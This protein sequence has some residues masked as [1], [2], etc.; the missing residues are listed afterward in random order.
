[1]IGLALAAMFAAAAGAEQVTAWDLESDDGGFVATPGLQWEW[2]AIASYGPASGFES[3]SAWGTGVDALYKNELPDRLTL[4]AVDLGGMTAPVIGWW[5]WVELAEGDFAWL[6]AW[7]PDSGAWVTIDPVYG[8][9]GNDAFDGGDPAWRQV[10]VDLTG[11]A[12]LSYLQLVFSPSEKI[13]AAGWYVDSFTLWEGDAVPPSLSELTILEDTQDVLGPYE[14]TVTAEDD[15]ALE[16]VELR[17]RVDGGAIEY[18]VAMSDQGDGS[19]AGWLPGQDP[20]TTLSYY[21]SATDGENQAVLPREE[22][23][24][25]RVYLPAPSGLTGPDTHLADRV[26]TLSWDPPDTDHPLDGYSV[27]RDGQLVTKVDSSPAEVPLAES[28]NRFSVSAVF[29]IGDENWDGD[30]SEEIEL[31]VAWPDLL[32]LSPDFAYQGDEVR[33]TLTGQNLLM[34][35]DDLALDLGG[36]VALTGLEVRDVDVAVAT[37]TIDADAE[38]GLRDLELTSGALALS[39]SDVFEVVDGAERPQLLSVEPA[40]LDQG[41]EAEL[42]ISTSGEIQPDALEVDLGEGVVVQ[43]VWLEDGVIVVEVGVDPSAALGDREIRVD[44]GLRILTGAS[45]EIMDRRYIPEK[46]CATTG[47]PEG[48]GAAG[49]VLGLLLLLGL[50]RRE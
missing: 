47:G 18:V 21:V 42:R 34:S 2:G 5:Q 30:R 26:A 3:A 13:Q 50:R 44:D 28:D 25:F 22:A 48:R 7:D 6:E 23:L 24:S 39:F 10:F 9:D 36:G 49:W 32:G 33:V 14:V 17:Y 46:S 20:G 19:W 12:D 38:V 29:V 27:W 37:L 8:Y 4:P 1:M 43:S 35:Q 16:A 45:L 11:I 15:R 41:D 31:D 40:S